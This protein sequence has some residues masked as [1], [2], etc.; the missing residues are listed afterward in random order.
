M[1]RSF[2]FSSTSAG[3]MRIARDQR[4]S[5]ATQ[6]QP[7]SLDC[8]SKCATQLTR[9]PVSY[10]CGQNRQLEYAGKANNETHST[11]RGVRR[12]LLMPSPARPG[13]VVALRHDAGCDSAKS[14]HQDQ[15]C[16]KHTTRSGCHRIMEQPLLI[17]SPLTL[18]AR[19]L[20]TLATFNS[21][22]VVSSTP[23]QLMLQ[24][25]QVACMRS[26]SVAHSYPRLPCTYTN[27]GRDH[28][29]R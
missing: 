18:S 14:Y 5:T 1:P 28:R 12:G 16:A 15:S 10:C 4:Q 26:C 2:F 7:R 6:V 3:P 11:A 20:S 17:D 21:T 9:W 19:H 25:A 27:T 22:V 29:R 13:S 8:P 23:K 24:N